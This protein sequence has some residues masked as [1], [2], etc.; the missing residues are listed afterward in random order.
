MVTPL[1]VGMQ[2]V[3]LH[4]VILSTLIGSC[5]FAIEAR[6]LQSVSELAKQAIGVMATDPAKNQQCKF[7]IFYIRLKNIR[8]QLLKGDS[9]RFLFA[10]FLMK[11]SRIQ[12]GTIRPGDRAQLHFD[13]IEK[14]LRCQRG[15]N[16]GIVAA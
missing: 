15:V 2:P 1:A 4:V 12:I 10:K 9:P 14:F 11:P 8:T 7:F 16:S 3:V 13:L 5:S 6:A